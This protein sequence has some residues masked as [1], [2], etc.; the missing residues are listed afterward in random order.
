M[1]KVTVCDPYGEAAFPVVNAYTLDE[2]REKFEEFKGMTGWR[3]L[4]AENAIESFI[5]FVGKEV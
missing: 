3:G 4:D 5:R 2:I 1:V